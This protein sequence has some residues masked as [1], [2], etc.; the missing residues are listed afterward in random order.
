MCGDVYGFVIEKRM[1]ETDEGEQ[2]PR[3]YIITVSIVT[4]NGCHEYLHRH[5]KII[6]TY[7]ESSF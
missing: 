2:T 7:A 5:N 6:L 3:Q 1:D 4:T